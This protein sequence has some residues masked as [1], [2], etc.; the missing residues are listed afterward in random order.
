MIIIKQKDME[1]LSDFKNENSLDIFTQYGIFQKKKTLCPFHAER[2]PSL[3]LYKSK[4]TNEWRFHCFGCGEDGD[5]F[6]FIG[7]IEGISFKDTLI[8]LGIKSGHVTKP[9]KNIIRKLELIKKFRDW[10][11]DYERFLRNKYRKWHEIKS[12]FKNM[13]EVEVFY[14]FY[15][16]ENIWE[17]QL[18][19]LLFGSEQEKFNLYKEF[20]RNGK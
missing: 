13:E 2:T 6:K 1:N 9:D 3:S 17:Y 10:C 19:I 8:F 5:I 15:H 12:Q 18:N 20:K 7:K 4:I 14:K 11:N 16:L